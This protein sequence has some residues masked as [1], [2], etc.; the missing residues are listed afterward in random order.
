[1]SAESKA[2]GSGGGGSDGSGGS[3]TG[4]PA[5]AAA[6]SG[7]RPSR[8][9]LYK[10]GA[11]VSALGKL[12]TGKMPGHTHHYHKIHGKPGVFRCCTCCLGLNLQATEEGESPS[13]DHMYQHIQCVHRSGLARVCCTQHLPPPPLRP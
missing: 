12:S 7:T 4:A 10:A 2:N 3:G 9:L 6:D 11:I 13:C 8:Q 1:M 5:P